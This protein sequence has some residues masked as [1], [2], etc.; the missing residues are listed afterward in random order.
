M[1]AIT[2]DLLADPGQGVEVSLFGRPTRLNGGAFAL[3]IAAGA[4]MIRVSGVWQSNSSVML[5]FE[6]APRAPEN[7]DREVAIQACVQDW[8]RWFEEK[9]RANPENWL[10]W[11]D[12]R[13]SRFLHETPRVSD[14]K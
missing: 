8:C 6:R 4:P 7:D 14:R 2:P 9:L 13:W 5:T 11:L 3:A 1:L 12:K 10:F